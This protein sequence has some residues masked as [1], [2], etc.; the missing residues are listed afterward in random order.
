M[1]I[2]LLGDGALRSARNSELAG[3]GTLC[4]VLDLESMCP[5]LDGSGGRC[6][7]PV[8]TNETARGGPGSL[9]PWIGRGVD[10]VGTLV[11][12]LADDCVDRA[13]DGD[14]E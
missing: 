1:A 5:G 14:C 13:R 6:R 2:W 3:S 7:L 8:T 4:G 12:Q 10:P 9:Q 11:E